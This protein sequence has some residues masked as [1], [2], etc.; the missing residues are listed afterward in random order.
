MRK[1]KDE[2]SMKRC[3]NICFFFLGFGLNICSKQT[4]KKKKDNFKSHIFVHIEENI[5]MIWAIFFI[6]KKKYFCSSIF[7]AL[8]TSITFI[9]LHNMVILFITSHN[10]NCVLNLCSIMIHNISIQT[11]KKKYIEKGLFRYYFSFNYIM[12]YILFIFERIFI[13][14]GHLHCIFYTSYH[15]QHMKLIT[16]STVCQRITNFRLK[17]GW[18]RF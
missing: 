16:I 2:S 13:F 12:L 11:V 5:F 6:R 1:K 3:L 14:L 7:D 15:Q 4:V 18:V 10:L 8:M 17:L 9:L